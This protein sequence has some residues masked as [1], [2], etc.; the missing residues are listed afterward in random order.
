MQTSATHTKFIIERKEYDVDN[1]NIK[2]YNPIEG[3]GNAIIHVSLLQFPA[4]DI[5][6]WAKK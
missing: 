5:F 4:G 1:F 6:L 3:T 2:V